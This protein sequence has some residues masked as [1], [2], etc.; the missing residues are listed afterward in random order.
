MADR[1]TAKTW[2]AALS[3]E[4]RLYI[5]PVDLIHREPASALVTQGQ[6][7]HLA[8]GP[9]AFS[10]VELRWRR[11]GE[12]VARQVFAVSDLQDAIAGAENA[13]ADR[14]SG[15]LNNLSQSR[16]PFAGVALCRPRIMGVVN[17]TPDSFS[18]GGLFASS[19]AAIDHG[20]R[21]WEEGADVI[22]IGGVSTRPGAD[23]VSVQ[24]E[25]DRVM[26]VVEGLCDLPA[27]ISIDTRSSAVMQRAVA[28]GAVIINDT[29]ALTADPDSLDVATELGAPVVLMHCLGD[30][31]TMQ[32]RP[33]YADVACDIYDYLDARVAACRANGIDINQVMI[34]PGIG[35]GKTVPHNVEILRDL[36][37]FHGVGAGL[38][39]GVSRKS[40]IGVLGSVAAA[41]NRV[42][43][44]LAAALW[45]LRL[46]AHVIRVHDV[47]DTKQAIAVWDAIGI[48]EIA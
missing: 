26:P 35:F 27:P 34:D 28:A 6:A 41:D 38:L 14:V 39:I 4:H 20:T 17:V 15:L 12:R 47:A 29:S 8:G 16:P 7:L 45:A 13:A 23:P 33:C 31:K 43:G 37:L 1:P 30:P 22:D 3:P 24:D 19:T 48:N 40:F 11:P 21:L 42:P 32:E 25:L 5:Q 2:L 46:G 10:R 44:S 9:S 36:A 18:D